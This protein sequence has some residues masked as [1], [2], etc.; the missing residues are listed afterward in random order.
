MQVAIGTSQ[1]IWVPLGQL[2]HMISSPKAFHPTKYC[3]QF[4]TSARSYCTNTTNFVLFWNHDSITS[5][6]YILFGYT[7]KVL[8][9]KWQLSGTE[10]NQRVVCKWERYRVDDKPIW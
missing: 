1:P 6:V 8:G 5:M 4:A 9:R 7:R 10:T 2:L 3:P